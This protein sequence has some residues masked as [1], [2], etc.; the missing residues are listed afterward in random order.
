MVRQ[1]L[2]DAVL[3]G[4]MMFGIHLMWIL[5]TIPIILAVIVV[6]AL[7]GGLPALLAGSIAGFFTQGATPWIVAAIVG[8]PIFLIVVIIPATLIGGWY[9]VFSSS[10]WTLTYREALVFE[11][12]KVNEELPVL[13]K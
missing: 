7:I 10:T 4:A 13:D 11:Q 3:M 6:A 5:I 8:A 2:G 12:I 1:R 9:Q